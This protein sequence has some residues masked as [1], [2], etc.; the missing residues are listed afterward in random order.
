MPEHLIAGYGLPPLDDAAEGQAI[1][2][3]NIARI[4]GLEVRAPRGRS[5]PSHGPRPQRDDRGRGPRGGSTRSSIRAARRGR[6]S[7]ARQ[8][9]LVRAVDVEALGAP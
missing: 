6:S 1:L 8:M 9:G 4:M 3:G 7:R 5:S 2:G